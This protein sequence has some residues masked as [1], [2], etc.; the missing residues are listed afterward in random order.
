LC[1]AFGLENLDH[2]MEE[3]TESKSLII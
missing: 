3:M 2:A 1:Q